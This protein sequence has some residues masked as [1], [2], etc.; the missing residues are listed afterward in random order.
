M[1]SAH[2]FAGV[3]GAALGFDR[4]GI[5]PVAFAEIDAG[6]RAVLAR[7]W[8][9]AAHH[10][11]IRDIT[12]ADLNNPDVITGGFPCQD[13][14]YANPN[15]VGLHGDRSVLWFD[16]LRLIDEAEPAFVVAENSPALRSRGLDDL[17]RSLNQ[18]GYDAEWYNIP[19]SY[20]GA[21]HKRDRIWLL[22][23]PGRQ[24]R[25]EGRPAG[26]ILGQPDLSRPL[27]GGT[28]QWPGRS[29]LSSSRFCGANDGVP[30]RTQRLR[31]L[32][33]S[34]YTPIPEMIARV[35]RDLVEADHSVRTVTAAEFYWAVTNAAAVLPPKLGLNLTLADRHAY[36]PMET[37]LSND[38]RSGF[39]I[40]VDGTLT[41]LFSTVRGRGDYLVE[42]AIAAGAT[43]L[44]A[45][46]GYLHDL[47]SRHGFTVVE[48]LTWDPQ[49]APDGWDEA[50]F[51]TPDVLLMERT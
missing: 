30:E 34:V 31:R 43:K 24:R 19:A 49:Y 6:N 10:G 46:D 9:Q 28:P 21:W 22:A 33:N 26:P 1:R 51:G 5:T 45:Y 8:P 42:Q 18:I 2:L 11:D 15:A 20:L 32:G 17:L 3:G 4:G 25:R 47:Y 12:A 38:G 40:N 44:D 36:E 50:A 7:H 16:M 48:R 39:A 23:Y 14:S 13:I 41:N 27:T 37:F 35:L 29:N